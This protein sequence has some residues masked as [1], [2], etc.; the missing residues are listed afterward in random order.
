[1]ETS[2]D[3]DRERR[4]IGSQKRWK[5]AKALIRPQTIKALVEV[6]KWVTQVI[7]VALAIIKF[8]RE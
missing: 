4:R 1:M 7:Y 8:L 2:K 5:W 3:I 6:G